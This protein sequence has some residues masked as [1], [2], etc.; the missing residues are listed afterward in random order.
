MTLNVFDE[1]EA[2]R[3]NESRRAF[4]DG[5]LPE[6]IRK[7]QLSTALD[8]GCGYGYFSKWL[9]CLG[10]RVTG[11]DGRPENVAEASRR[12]PGIEFKTFDVE[13][14]SITG[15]GSFDLVLCVGL[16]YHLESP[17]RAIRNLCA[18]S[19]LYLVIETQV[20]PHRSPVTL[21]C[22][23]GVAINQSLAY[24]ACVPSRSCL[25]KMLY[26]A[27]FPNV[28]G[29]IRP[30]DYPDFHG[31]LLRRKLRIVMLASKE[32]VEHPNFRPVPEPR[33]RGMSSYRNIFRVAKRALK[34]PLSLHG[35]RLL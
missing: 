11:I 27:G 12:Y 14:P 4:L 17:F 2:S 15:L 32:E 26:R 5:L 31:S 25:V 29:A 10:L 23:E 19:H 9:S 28:Y 13:D 6:L 20:A 16:L 33:V 21:L 35:A 22:E 3:F 18:L 7:K 34:W 1:P 8:V 24:T 30:P